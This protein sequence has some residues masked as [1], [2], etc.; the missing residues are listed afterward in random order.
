MSSITLAQT[1]EKPI[2]VA[3]EE[4]ISNLADSRHGFPSWRFP[5]RMR[6]L[7]N[8]YGCAGNI[9]AALN[10]DNDALIG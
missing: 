8:L 1:P 3:T 2:T 7:R 10:K 9:A 4:A 5:I 6:A